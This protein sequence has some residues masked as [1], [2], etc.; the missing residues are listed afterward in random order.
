M[1]TTIAIAIVSYAW[2]LFGPRA[3]SLDVTITVVEAESGQRIPNSRVFIHAWDYGIFDT[4]PLVFSALSDEEGRVVLERR[5]P[6]AIREVSVVA[7]HDGVNK[8][9]RNWSETYVGAWTSGG[10]QSH[11]SAHHVHFCPNRAHFELQVR[12]LTQQERQS[13]QLHYDADVDRTLFTGRYLARE[14]TPQ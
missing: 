6:F 3:R 12:E 11:D 1:G 8:R 9:G 10:S 5:L 4:N 2:M 7:W 14:M 13:A